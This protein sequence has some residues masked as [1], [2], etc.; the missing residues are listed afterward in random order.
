[1]N[2]K[3]H[4]AAEYSRNDFFRGIKSFD[5]LEEKIKK[6]HLFSKKNNLTQVEASL[7]FVFMQKKI[8]YFFIGINRS[9]ELLQLIKIIKKINVKKELSFKQ[10]AI[11]DSKFIN[12]HEWQL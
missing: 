6:L 12:P 7:L 1:M 3:H 2:A 11:K 8:K 4:K 9:Q 5:Q 10:F